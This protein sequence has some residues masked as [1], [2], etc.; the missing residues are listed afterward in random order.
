MPADLYGSPPY[1]G[2]ATLP[3]TWGDPA[4]ANQGGS[5]SLLSGS[6]SASHAANSV[7]GQPESL[8]DKIVSAYPVYTTDD[9]KK[10][11]SDPTNYAPSLNAVM[12][13]FGT[14]TMGAAKAGQVM[15]AA[16]PDAPWY[17]KY[18]PFLGALTLFILGFLLLSKGFDAVTGA[19]STIINLAKGVAKA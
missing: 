15:N 6:D 2:Y 5:S 12:P 16:N 9:L 13:G 14:A 8:W 11:F 7:N 4:L 1:Q 3:L 19:K 10:D 18:R 17:I